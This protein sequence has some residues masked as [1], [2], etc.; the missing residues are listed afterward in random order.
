MSTE[1]NPQPGRPF[2]KTDNISIATVAT[3]LPEDG[4]IMVKKTR[5]RNWNTTNYSSP[6]FN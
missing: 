3:V 1:D 6:Y 2:I 4:R 5:D